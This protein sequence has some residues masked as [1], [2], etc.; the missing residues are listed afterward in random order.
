MCFQQVCTRVIAKIRHN[1][2]KS[3]LRQNAGWLDKNHSGALTT[4]LN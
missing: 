4:K 3:I 1:Y 2:V